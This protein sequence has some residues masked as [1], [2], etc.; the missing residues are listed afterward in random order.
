MV[1]LDLHEDDREFPKS[2]FYQ[3]FRELIANREDPD[4][5]GPVIEKGANAGCVHCIYAMAN[6]WSDDGVSFHIALP[7]YLE[8]AIRGSRSCIKPLYDC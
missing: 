2:T 5:W 1:K 4:E 6:L 3:R 7:W 8:G